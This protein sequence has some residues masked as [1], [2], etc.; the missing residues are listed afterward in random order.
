MKVYILYYKWENTAN[1]HAGMAYLANQIKQHYPTKVVLIKHPY[2]I[3]G[4]LYF[5]R[6]LYRFYA[7]V[8]AWYISIFLKF[9]LKQ[10][11]KL[12]FMEYA[13]KVGG[14]QQYVAKLLRGLHVKNLFYGLVHI[15][16]EQ[17]KKVF[18]TE[19]QRTF[20]LL[21]T[22]LVLGSSLKE[23]LDSAHLQ[24]N[25]KCTYHYVDTDYYTEN[26]TIRDNAGFRII[27][28]GNQLRNNQLLHEIVKNTPDVNFDICTGMQNLTELFS[29]CENATLY[30]FVSEEEL[31][32]LMQKAS[33]SLNVMN[34]TV[35]SNVITTSM[36]CGLAMIVSDV[37][38]IRDYCNDTNAYFCENNSSSFAKAINKLS[39]DENKLILMQKESL[40][41]ANKISLKN[42]LEIKF[43]KLLDYVP[44]N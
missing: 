20:N 32:L 23:Y 13:S 31:L 19:I 29:D 17:I 15:P 7:T 3:L 30:G 12:F 44:D 2:R 27:C 36:A 24:G 11:D 33:V 9:S 1:N 26:K 14:D 4:H 8:W 6:K 41:I 38:S 42:F 34:D 21:D 16:G 40:V 43:L 28:M 35:G 37:G 39:K 10:D 22:I 18:K 5:G 25:V